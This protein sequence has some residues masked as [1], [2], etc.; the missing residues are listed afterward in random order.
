MTS[1]C[2]LWFSNYNL[3]V[4]EIP[5]R[6]RALHGKSHLSNLISSRL[7][8]EMLS[9]LLQALYTVVEAVS[10]GC[11]LHL[12]MYR[13]VFSAP[14]AQAQMCI[15]ADKASI[16]SPLLNVLNQEHQLIS[17]SPDVCPV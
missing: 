13:H 5:D 1:S 16:F 9:I 3:I 4:Q 8:F 10:A 7:F 12:A 15:P 11:P 6:D 14:G 2:R 17:S